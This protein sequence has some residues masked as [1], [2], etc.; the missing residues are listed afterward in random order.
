MSSYD[1]ISRIK[2]GDRDA[3][4]ILCRERYASMISY[5][6]LFLKGDWAEDVV[7]D[8]LFGVWQRRET[9]DEEQNLQGY[10]I[11]SIYNRCMNYLA[12]EKRSKQYASY[13]QRKVASLMAS[14]YSPDNNPT[15]LGLYNADLRQKLEKA[16]ENLTPRCREVFTLSY[17]EH[18]SE[19][20]IS[21]R[22]GLSLSTVENHMYLALKQLR[23][24]LT[25]I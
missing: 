5:A 6:R 25:N 8:V 13:Y 1:I 19:R 23:L 16:I 7:Q 24:S 15:I 22:L 9:L 17:I 3:F 11:R 20:E 2:S 21:E 4:D 10:L 18:L 14:Y 12:D